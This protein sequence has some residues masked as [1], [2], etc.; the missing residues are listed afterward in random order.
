MTPPTYID[1]LE[2]EE[3]KLLKD[4]HRMRGMGYGTLRSGP[5]RTIMLSQIEGTSF[6][7]FRVVESGVL[8]G[9]NNVATAIPKAS[10][11][12]LKHQKTSPRGLTKK[13]R[14]VKRKPV[15]EDADG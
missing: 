2:M 1:L 15:R 12:A 10:S 5:G 8:V 13:V 7:T 4:G 14:A 9:T 11:L 6:V 3:L